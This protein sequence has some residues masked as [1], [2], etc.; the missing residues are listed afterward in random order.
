MDNSNTFVYAPLISQS[1]LIIMS[2]FPTYPL[3]LQAVPVIPVYHV[4]LISVPLPVQV[5]SINYQPQYPDNTYP[6]CQNI[7]YN[8]ENKNFIKEGYNIGFEKVK[9]EDCEK[10]VK[11]LHIENKPNA[12]FQRYK[13][14]ENSS[15]ELESIKSEKNFKK[16]SKKVSKQR[17]RD[18]LKKSERIEVKEEYLSSY[19]TEILRTSNDE[20]ESEDLCDTN[21]NKTDTNST[22]T[23]KELFNNNFLSLLYS[24]E[25]Y[26]KYAKELNFDP[27]FIKNY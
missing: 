1:P 4:P 6:E 16:T 13:R 20:N 9:D 11:K 8:E 15:R 19:S 26:L 14:E 10:I 22:F 18:K 24:Y 23:L 7:V 21:Q 5:S 27:Q 3:I 25:K 2:H 12:G 17:I